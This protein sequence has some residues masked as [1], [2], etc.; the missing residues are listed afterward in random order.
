MAFAYLP[1]VG[2]LLIWSIVREK[3]FQ[4]FRRLQ[5]NPAYYW[6]VAFVLINLVLHQGSG[7]N[8]DSRLGAMSAFS[9]THSFAFDR[10]EWSMDVSVTPDG[11]VYSNKAPGPTLLGLPLFYLIDFPLVKWRATE[12][13]R[14]QKRFTSKDAYYIPLTLFLQIVPYALAV[15]LV[16]ETLAGLGL[17]MAALHFAAL[18]MLF[19]NTVAV[20]VNTYFGHA[21][22]AYFLLAMTLALLARNYFW[23]A[24]FFGWALL[25]DYGAVCVLP[26]LIF[27][28]IWQ[29]KDEAASIPKKLG[30]VLTGAL[31]PGLLWIWYH[32]V[33][34]GGPF[35]IALKYQ[36]SSMHNFSDLKDNVW[37]IMSL[38]PKTNLV[39]ELLLGS[40]RGVLW[41]QPWVLLV[42]LLT[43]FF[44]I[45]KRE[46]LTLALLSVPSFLILLMMNAT[47]GG[48]WG[49]GSSGPRYLSI[50]MPV[51]AI[52]GA[53]VFERSS[54]SLKNLLWLA[55]G[56]SLCLTWL[57]HST[58][59]QAEPQ[60]LWRWLWARFLNPQYFWLSLVRGFFF[61][62]VLGWAA[63][64]TR[65][66]LR[67][68]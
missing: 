45:K 47:F 16:I 3:L 56:F 9:E 15:A 41:T 52:F 44:F 21:V 39:W 67:L 30:L 38:F 48:W 58:T 24:F 53:L 46:F 65:K 51:I 27:L 17:S 68:T 55:L 59:T 61:V 7:A 18:A 12:A 62:I 64:K 40:K 11:K 10:T 31:V 60:A 29:A 43:P 36:A 57:I 32:T 63:L 66:K 34:F 4:L 5:A 1:K 13:E 8:P 37:G 20:F 14:F 22:A 19:G 28:W 35:E 33:C 50:L 49:G 54:K 23:S 25:S 2:T 26:S 6:I 42:L